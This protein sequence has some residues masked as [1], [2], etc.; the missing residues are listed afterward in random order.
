MESIQFMQYQ[1]STTILRLWCHTCLGIC[2]HRS[3]KFK[4]RS[5]NVGNG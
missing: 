1:L 3:M 5:L 2:L 4:K